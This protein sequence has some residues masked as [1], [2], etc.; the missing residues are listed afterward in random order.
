MMQFKTDKLMAKQRAPNGGS[1][2]GL[3]ARTQKW[4]HRFTSETEYAD[5]TLYFGRRLKIFREWGVRPQAGDHVLQVGCG[6]GYFAK[7]LLGSGFRVTACDHSDELLHKTEQRCHSSMVAGLIHTRLLDVNKTPLPLD[8]PYDH[9]I[10]IMRSFF[11]YCRQPQQTLRELFRLTRTKLLVDLDPREF[12]LRSA[13]TMVHEAGFQHI[14]VRAFLTP[15]KRILPW[16][17]QRVLWSCERQPLLYGPVV[18]RKFHMWIVAT[19]QG[20]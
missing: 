4:A 10:A 9:T 16:L 1:S 19:K 17:L 5:P 7:L 6:D 18:Q 11:H 14:R 13:K 20:H 15:Q 3:S 8:Q 12:P 2:L